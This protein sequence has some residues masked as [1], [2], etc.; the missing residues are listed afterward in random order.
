VDDGN[1]FTDVTGTASFSSGDWYLVNFH[2]FV[3]GFQNGK[4]PLVYN[5]TTS[6]QVADGNAPKGAIGTAAFGRVWAV[7][8]DGHTIKY[9]ALLDHTNWTT[10]DSGH[11]DMASIWPNNDHVVAITAYN[12]FLVIFGSRNIVVWND[13]S[14]SVLG[15]N[16]ATMKV[17]DTVPGLGCLHQRTVQNVQGDLWFI[18]SNRELTNL[19]RVLVE[20]KSGQLTTLSIHV[21]DLLRD[22]IDNGSFDVTRIRSAYSPKDRFYLL[23]LPQL[24]APGV[25]PADEVGKVFVFDTRALLEDGTARCV[26][27]WDTL[28]PTSIIMRQNGYWYSSLMTL[29]GRLGWYTG[30][31]MYNHGNYTMVFESGWLD[32][33]QKGYLLIMKRLKGLFLF[34]LSTTVVLKWAFDFDT[35]F[36]KKQITWT[37]SG[38]NAQ[39]GLSEWGIAEWGGGI[40]LS[41]KKI[42]GT[43]TGQYIKVGFEATIAGGSFSAQ[44]LDIYAKVG[45]LKG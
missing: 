44:E 17:V 24:S 34:D 19:A 13:P 25:S 7:D 5:G 30:N 33:T 43:G 32:I 38:G 9:C 27:L 21:S 40:D 3:I 36:R 20:S 8:S 4:A 1:T 26:G 39:W 29:T 31:E 2:D 14:G 42:T 28:V 35:N 15:M 23:S 45:R 41:S 6:S 12:N 11:I 22:S 16:P 18:G 10:G 37:T